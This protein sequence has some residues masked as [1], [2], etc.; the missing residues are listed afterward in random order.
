MCRG[1]SQYV[2]LR[3]GNITGSVYSETRSSGR[4]IDTLPPDLTS[5][6]EFAAGS[7][8]FISL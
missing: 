4:V 1:N 8:L 3:T 7:G 6:S 5:G 2:T